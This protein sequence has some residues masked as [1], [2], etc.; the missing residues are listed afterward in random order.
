MTGVRCPGTPGWATCS[1]CIGLG[2]FLL[3][4]LKGRCSHKW[5][6][7]PNTDWL[8]PHKSLL[9]QNKLLPHS[10]RLSS[11]SRALTT[12]FLKHIFHGATFL[13]NDFLVPSCP[14]ETA[15]TL[16]LQNGVLISSPPP[17]PYAGHQTRQIVFIQILHMP[18]ML[19]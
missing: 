14:E 7:H 5:N 3:T 16:S 18:P 15:Y 2:I 13:C 9:P 8:S 6:P 1:R 10:S 17:P 19:G 11:P 4:P 12:I